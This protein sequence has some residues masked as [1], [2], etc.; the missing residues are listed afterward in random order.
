MTTAVRP[1]REAIRFRDASPED[2]PFLE[3]LYAT[4]RIEE[5]KVVPWTPDQKAAFIHQQFTAQ[6]NH[7]E[8]FYPDCKFLVIEMEGAPIGRLYLDREEENIEIVDIALLPEF[9]GRGI[10]RMLLEEILAEGAA[11]GKA[12]G[13][14]VENFNPARQLYDKLGFRHIADNGVYHQMEWR[15]EFKT[16]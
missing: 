3:Y 16:T 5:M 8:E 9:R 15:S 14:Y 7:Y 6:K 13:I 2:V 4:T 1:P 11:T 10:G 12:V